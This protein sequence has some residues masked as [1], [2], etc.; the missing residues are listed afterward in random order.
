MYFS[1]RPAPP[2]P[3]P[4]SVAVMMVAT[5]LP[6]DGELVW[7]RQWRVTLLCH[8][9]KATRAVCCIVTGPWPLDL[10][11]NLHEV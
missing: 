10:E 11:T 6:G 2:R 5:F 4:G 3:A 8:D 7:C 9:T 1:P